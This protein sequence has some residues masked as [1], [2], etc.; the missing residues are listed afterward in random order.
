MCCWMQ[1][2]HLIISIHDKR[3]P[4]IVRD[5]GR[6]A[7]DHLTK[8]NSGADFYQPLIAEGIVFFVRKPLQHDANSRSG[9]YS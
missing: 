6:L 4:N 8:I 1:Y 9:P 2:A 5:Y 7:G 3:L